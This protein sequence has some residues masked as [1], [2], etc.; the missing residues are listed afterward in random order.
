MALSQKCSKYLLYSATSVKTNP[1]QHTH[2]SSHFYNVKFGWPVPLIRASIDTSKEDADNKMKK[3]KEKP[4]YLLGKF[5]K[6]VDHIFHQRRIYSPDNDVEDDELLEITKSTS[7]TKPSKSDPSIFRNPTQ[8]IK[9]DHFHQLMSHPWQIIT[10]C[11]LDG[12]AKNNILT[13]TQ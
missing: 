3:L 13:I 7:K 1:S 10:S 9:E 4:A 6:N 8:M 2:K 5:I 12:V 11:N